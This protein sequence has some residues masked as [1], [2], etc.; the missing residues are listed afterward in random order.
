[1]LAVFLLNMGKI[2]ICYYITLAQPLINLI[3]S[4]VLGGHFEDL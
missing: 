2:E 4:S 1:M 3:S